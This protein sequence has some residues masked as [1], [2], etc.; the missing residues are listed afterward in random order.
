[1]SPISSKVS[2]GL[3]G[4]VCLVTG[5][6]QGIGEACVRRFVH[7]GARAVLVDV[8]DAQGQALAAELG[9]TFIHCDVGD[10][11]QVDAMVARCMAD[12]LSWDLIR[13]GS[14]K[15]S[16]HCELFQLIISRGANR[17]S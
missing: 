16:F 7:D 9:A 8:D 10:K 6:A 3:A 17:G 5:G 15:A 14:V 2:F 1:M 11:A 4:R 13:A 12:F